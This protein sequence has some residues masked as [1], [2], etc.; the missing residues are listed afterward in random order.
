[1]SL[2]A[3]LADLLLG[4]HRAPRHNCGYKARGPRDLDRHEACCPWAPRG[5]G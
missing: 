1:M 5:A 3:F 2:L 4:L